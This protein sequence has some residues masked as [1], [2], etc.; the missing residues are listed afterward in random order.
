[1]L[2]GEGGLHSSVDIPVTG[3]STGILKP[4]AFLLFV[5]VYP[6]EGFAQCWIRFVA[7]FKHE[8]YNHKV[9]QCLTYIKTCSF[10]HF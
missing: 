7:S 4:T 9:N 6:L 5:S 2:K 1:M 10:D 8:E 3:N